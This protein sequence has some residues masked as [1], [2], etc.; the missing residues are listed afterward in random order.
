MHADCHDC[1]NA[2]HT[3]DEVEDTF[4]RNLRSISFEVS[5]F[6]SIGDLAAAKVSL[7]E[8]YARMQMQ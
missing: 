7:A 2:N 1:Y 4:H 5:C 3:G 6:L 8:K